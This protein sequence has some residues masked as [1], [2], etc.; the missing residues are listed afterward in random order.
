MCNKSFLIRILFNC[1]TYTDV[2]AGSHV[3]A[4]EHLRI[5]IGGSLQDQ[6]LYDVGN[7]KTPCHLFQKVSWGLFGFSKGCLHMSRW[8]DLNQ[9]FKTTG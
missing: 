4:F 9:L 6:V 3:K 2:V 8:D 5:R 1:N 7:L